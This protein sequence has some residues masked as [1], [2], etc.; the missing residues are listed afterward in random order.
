MRKQSALG[1]SVLE[2][3]IVL[4]I[5]CVLSTAAMVGLQTVRNATYVNDAYSMV[6]REV[7]TAHQLAID[8]RCIAQLTFD[9]N[10]TVPNAQ[11]TGTM[12]I[13]LI[14]AGVSRNYETPQ[15]LPPGIQFTTFAG[16]PVTGS[17]PAGVPPDGFGH[18]MFAVDFG[19]DFGGNKTDIYFQPNGTAMDAATGGQI[20]N[21]VVYFGRPAQLATARAVSLMGATGRV[22]GWRLL[23]VGGASKWK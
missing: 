2:I 14:K 21:G 1:F 18:G 19:T 12:L 9:P 13:Q 15:L 3:L 4:S 23:T 7:Q 20:N 8:Q 5:I 17:L 22:K 10:G 16:M 6:L 11:G